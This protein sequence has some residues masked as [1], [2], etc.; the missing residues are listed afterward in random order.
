[1]DNIL[2][3][4]KSLLG[5]PGEYQQFDPQLIVLINMQL[6]VLRQL[7]IGPT[8]PPFKI[9]DGSESWDDYIGEEDIDAVQTYIYLKVRLLFDPPTSSSV[10]QAYQEQIRELEW[11]LNVH[12]DLSLEEEEETDTDL[13]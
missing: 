2:I 1:M 10:Q 7:G 5:I 11:R 8:D 12:A 3:T 9:I 6:N 13:E 4:I